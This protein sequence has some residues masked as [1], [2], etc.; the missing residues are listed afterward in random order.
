[1]KREFVF[2]ENCLYLYDRDWS[3]SSLPHLHYRD[4]SFLVK[5]KAVVIGEM[6]YRKAIF[7]DEYHED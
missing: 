1:M 3:V 6:G 4:L 7:H 2:A 5:W